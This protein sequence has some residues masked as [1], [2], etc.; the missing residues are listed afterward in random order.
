MG[1]A[2]PLSR[3]LD[4]LTASCLVQAQ[5]ATAPTPVASASLRQ[6]EPTAQDI[7]RLINQLGATG[8]KERM[9]ATRRLCE[10][11]APAL[12]ALRSARSHESFEVATRA[13]SL[14]QVL[15]Q[16]CFAGVKVTL[17]V[18]ADRVA[19]DTPF[20]VVMELENTSNRDARVPFD[21][22]GAAKRAGTATQADQVAVMMDAGDMLRVTDAAGRSIDMR[23]DEIGEDNDVRAVVDR[24]SA[25]SPVS[26]LKPGEKATVTLSQFNRGFA[27]FPLL[28]PGRATIA[29]EYIPDWPDEEPFESFATQRVG[30]VRG[31][32][33][34]VAVE[35][36]APET[37]SL[38]GRGADLAIV[39]DG[40]DLVA[41]LT[42]VYDK[43][44][45]VNLLFGN[46]L[47]FA[48]GRWV[49]RVAGED[50]ILPISERE[51]QTL[52][53]FTPER[54]VTVQPGASMDLGRVPLAKVHKVC[55]SNGGT[56]QV[57]EVF[58]VYGNQTSRAW[59][60]DQARRNTATW[61]SMPA[62]IREPLPERMLTAHLQSEPLAL[63]DQ[64]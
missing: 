22:G 20:D 7:E 30:A 21:L 51:C 32:P 47:P 48:Q 8:Y 26:I 24:R 2:R 31:E 63:T 11:G 43:P 14:V 25:S 5:P 38:S 54:I 18:S 39:R 52:A 3:P 9:E 57:C 40:Q 61:K 36:G 6:G 29:F 45:R 28:R 50:R 42:C 55:E 34:S 58:A 46:G 49:C 10:I 41:R 56:A 4:A 64:P 16:V 23:V 19:W 17:R 1:A 59:Q 13:A 27:R 37:L 60:L 33:V 44:V 12:D 53:D 35:P 15:E 62:A